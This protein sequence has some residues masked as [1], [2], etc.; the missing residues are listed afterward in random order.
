MSVIEDGKGRG[1]KAAVDSDNDLQTK[2]VI[3]T[4]NNHANVE[5]QDAYLYY[6]D[7]TPTAS[8][9]VCTYIKNT[10]QTKNLIV[11]WYRV[12]TGT[13]AEALDL[14]F[15]PVGT[16]TSTTTIVPKNM[17]LGSKKEPTGDFFSGN[18][19]GGLVGSGIVDRVRLAGNGEDVISSWP[20]NI[21]L[22]PGSSMML[23]ALTGGFS[24]EVTISFYY[25][26]LPE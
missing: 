13:D 15:N 9:S 10:D 18:S 3:S 26:N 6:A 5:H 24:T 8:G 2:S 19:I 22:T 21:I 17:N 25:D 12:W 20:G 1:F 4:I 16:P 7:M 23:T 14:Y 11:D